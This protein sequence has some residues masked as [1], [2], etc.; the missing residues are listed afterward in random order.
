MDWDSLRGCHS[1]SPGIRMGL[2]VLA[3]STGY[4]A[5]LRTRVLKIGEKTPEQLL[6][7]LAAYIPHENDVWLRENMEAHNVPAPL[8]RSHPKQ[9]YWHQ[10]LEETGT[11][12][13]QYNVCANDP[14]QRFSE[15]AAAVLADADTH[16]VKPVV[17]DLR[18]NGGGD[19]R[20]IRPLMSGLV[21]R[22]GKVGPF[23]VLIG[24]RTF[25]S[26]VDNAV[27]LRDTL[28]ATLM[29][30]ATGGK[31]SSYG[32]LKFVVLPNSKVKVRYTSK[33][34]AARK[35]STSGSLAPDVPAPRNL[36][37]ALSGRDPALEAALS[38]R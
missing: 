23:Y 27:E 6:P 10:Y 38:A 1:R 21:K 19:S 37:A 33:W 24:P 5:A 25:S 12:F 8:F 22:L 28:H 26:A 30:E 31:A 14:K 2:P 9:D 3:S 20:V 13:I 18:E 34:F 35:D 36:A 16:T 29:G 11:L 32:E 15:F 4:E 7:E 17:I